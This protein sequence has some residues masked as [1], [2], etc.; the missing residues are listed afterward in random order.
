MRPLS[1]PDSR[2]A[3]QR[4]NHTSYGREGHFVVAAVRDFVRNGLRAH[5]ITALNTVPC[6]AG[7]ARCGRRGAWRGRS[8]SQHFRCAGPLCLTG[9]AQRTQGQRLA[10]YVRSTLAKQA[11]HRID[12]QRLAVLAR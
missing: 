9:E 3:R 5:R 7:A 10:A 4:R 12:Q 8:I 1:C 2:L 11:A 6:V